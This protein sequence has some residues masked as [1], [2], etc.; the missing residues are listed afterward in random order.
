MSKD[1]LAIARQS[2]L[3]PAGL[4]DND[5]DKVMGHLLGTSIDA[6]D[7]YFQVSRYESWI[8]ED[9]IVKEGSHNI[10]KGAGVRAVSGE[11]TGFAYSDDID[12][13]ALA[14]CG[15]KCQEYCKKR[16]GGTPENSDASVRFGFVRPH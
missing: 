3:S 15:K 11:K 4:A 12:L 13:T 9:G 5:I 6:A 1:P 10:E 14:G 7:I 2:I 16:A 8:L